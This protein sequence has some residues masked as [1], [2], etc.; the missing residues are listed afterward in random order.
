[1]PVSIIVSEDYS[2]CH[3]GKC[4]AGGWELFALMGEAYGSGLPLGYI[5][6]HSDGEGDTGAKERLLTQF[7]GHFVNTWQIK[8]IVTLC[9]KDW[10][11]INALKNAFPGVKIQLCYWHALRAVKERLKI[12]KRQPGK[13]DVHRARDE[14]D[15]I[16]PSFV[17]VKELSDEQ[18]CFPIQISHS[19]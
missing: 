8:P 17:P 4:A 3:T 18:V 15:W 12:L 2:R 19:Q 10:S 14:L 6:I 13:Y 5:F 16:D 7:F 1:M 9:D 11:E